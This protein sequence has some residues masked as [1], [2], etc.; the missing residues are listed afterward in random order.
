[1]LQST[2]SYL[3]LS[4]TWASHLLVMTCLT[5]YTSANKGSAE[6]YANHVLHQP[7]SICCG[8]LCCCRVFCCQMLC[9]ALLTC[10]ARLQLYATYCMPYCAVLLCR[11]VPCRA[12]I[13]CRLLCHAESCN[14]VL[15]ECNP[16]HV[17][18]QAKLHDDNLLW[19]LHIPRAR[20]IVYPSVAAIWRGWYRSRHS[21]TGRH[22]L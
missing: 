16:M 1:M 5:R 6:H 17:G 19:S 21:F 20:L 9:H 13:P 2:P 15:Y 14:A 3:S 22:S 7:T 10:C 8:V 18:N 4:P 12:I 11:S